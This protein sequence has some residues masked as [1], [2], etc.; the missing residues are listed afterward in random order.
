MVAIVD[1][2]EANGCLE[3]GSGHHGEL[4]PTDE[5]GCIRADVVE[6]FEWVTLPVR[7]GQTLWFHSRTPHRSGANHSGTDRRALYPTWKCEF[8][9]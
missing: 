2:D 4:L 5:F 1:S 6:S 7:A 8:G 9:G 3:A